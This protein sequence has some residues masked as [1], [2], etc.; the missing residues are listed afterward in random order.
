MSA[1]VLWCF[2]IEKNASILQEFVDVK[3]RYKDAKDKWKRLKN[4][5]ILYGN[6]PEFSYPYFYQ[7]SLPNSVREFEVQLIGEKLNHKLNFFSIPDTIRDGSLLLMNNINVGSGKKRIPFL[8]SISKI[9]YNNI[10][11]TIST[12]EKFKKLPKLKS[13]K[14]FYNPGSS[15]KLDFK[16]NFIASGQFEKV[17]IP[18]CGA[19]GT[20]YIIQKWENGRWINVVNTWEYKCITTFH[21]VSEH[22]FAI[23]LEEIGCYRLFLSGIIGERSSKIEVYSNIFFVR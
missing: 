22:K 5:Y 1:R 4:D 8:Y 19:P 9:L 17:K 15:I 2:Q 11:S 18:G 16:T 10:D 21:E 23:Q 3:V 12:L 7:L 14:F 13:E 20:R 6:Q